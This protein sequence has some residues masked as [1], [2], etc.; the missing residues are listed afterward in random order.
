MRLYKCADFDEAKCKGFKKCN[1]K[2]T[3]DPRHIWKGHSIIYNWVKH[4]EPIEVEAIGCPAN[5]DNCK[6]EFY[7]DVDSN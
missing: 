1:C 7:C 2:Y 4:K 3:F 6:M 5:K